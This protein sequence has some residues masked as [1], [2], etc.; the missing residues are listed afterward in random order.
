MMICLNN[1]DQTEVLFFYFCKFWILM[2]LPNTL[3]C[4]PYP[5]DA[6]NGLQEPVFNHCHCS[7]VSGS[8]VMLLVRCKNE[9][10]DWFYPIAQ[11]IN[12]IKESGRWACFK[13]I[14]SVK[15]QTPT[16]GLYSILLFNWFTLKFEMVKNEWQQVLVCPQRVQQS[17][18]GPKIEV[19]E[20]RGVGGGQTLWRLPEQSEH[21]VPTGLVF[22]WR[23]QG[24]KE[25]GKNIYL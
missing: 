3:V 21:Y 14:H 15:A 18:N 23:L 4:Q 13:P 16:V 2:L 6:N 7:S 20:G 1:N 19:C 22:S 24:G 10:G 25:G 17:V 9:L 11:H 5:R 12:P 8:A